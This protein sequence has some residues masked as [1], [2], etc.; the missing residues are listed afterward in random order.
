MIDHAQAYV[1]GQIH[2]NGAENFWSLFKR[3]INGTYIS[4][5]PF[6]SFRYVDEQ[7][8][9]F[10]TRKNADGEKISDGE[11]FSRVCRQVAGRRL[12][13]KPSPAKTPPHRG[14]PLSGRG[15]ASGR[16]KPWA[17]LEA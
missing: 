17:S 3:G 9:R 1:D 7:S 2:T 10:N 14:R 5:E 8:F 13:W 12:T 11:R 6:H 16:I 4:V 15:A